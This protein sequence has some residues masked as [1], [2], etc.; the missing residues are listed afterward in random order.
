MAKFGSVIGSYIVNIFHTGETAYSILAQTHKKSLSLRT[1]TNHHQTLCLPTDEVKAWIPAR[2]Q[3]L[4]RE[5]L[6]CY[7]RRLAGQLPVE[8]MSRADKEHLLRKYVSQA[9][10][11]QLAYEMFARLLTAG[12]QQRVVDGFHNLNLRQLFFVSYANVSFVGREPPS[13]LAG[14]QILD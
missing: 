3:P 12:N 7:R 8:E 1:Y 2:L 4:F 9:E 11:F 10:G 13:D 14:F 6:G 5:K